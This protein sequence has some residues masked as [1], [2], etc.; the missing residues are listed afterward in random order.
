MI[1]T[2]LLEQGKVPLALA[3]ATDVAADPSFAVADR[4]S[5]ATDIATAR[6]QPR[7][8]HRRAITARGILGRVLLATTT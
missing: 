6:L 5:K 1:A 2:F 3:Y 8:D 4:L 7:R